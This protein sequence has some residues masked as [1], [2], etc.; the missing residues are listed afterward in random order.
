[1]PSAESTPAC[2]GTI[3]VGSRAAARFRTRA[4]RRRRRTRRSA[5][6]AR[7]V[8]AL[9]RHDANRALHV[10][11]GDAHDAF[12]QLGDGQL[13]SLA[14]IAA[15]R[16]GARQIDRHAAAEEELRIQP[17]E[18]QVRVG[19]GQFFADAVADRTGHRARRLRG[20]TRSAPPRVDV[21]DRAA[22]GADGVDVDHRQPDG[23]VADPANRSIVANRA[24]DQADVG[25]RAA[26]VER[27][28]AIGNLRRAPRPAR[29]RRRRRGRR[30]RCAPPARARA[31]RRSIRRST[32]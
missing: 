6:R 32:A 31:P 25:G 9:D 14:Q 1:M 5:N 13:Q 11:V 2:R 27:N 17:A 30:A 18:Q 10:G 29:R 23:K 20:P 24:V 19:D 26:H 21:G 12:G 16:C 28:D 15:A 7:V 22:A 3:T 8:A 4:C